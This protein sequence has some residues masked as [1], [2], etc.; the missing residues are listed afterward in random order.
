[1]SE[2]PGEHGVRGEGGHPA[3]PRPLAGVRVL[4]LSRLLPGPLATK[5]LAELG[6]QVDKIED[7]AGGDY[8][9]LMPP[10]AGGMNAVFHALNLGHRSAVLDLKKPEGRAALLRL[11]TRYDVVVESFRPGVLDRLG[12]G[13]GALSAANP[14]LVYCAITG[15]GQTGPLAHRAG[16]DVD[17]LAR[18]GV[19]GM[20]GPEGAAPQ[21]PGMQVA[22]VGGGALFAVS[23]ILAA[24]VA[25]GVTGRGRFVDVSMCEGA[26]AFGLFGL[27]SRYGGMVTPA[28][29]DVLGGGIAPYNT[30]RTRDG[31]AVALGALEPKF[32]GAF[33]RGVGLPFDLEALA[34]GPHQVACKRKVA[35][36]IATRTRDEW[37]AFAA[38]NDCCL[39]PVLEPDELPDDPQH[40]AR[41]VFAHATLAD[42]TRLP[43]PRTPL[44]LGAPIDA[45][46]VAPRHGAHTRE[47]LREAGFDDAEITALGA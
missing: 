20:T 42:G 7:P 28:G 10:Q 15:Y 14:R 13:F 32:W 33:C 25:R 23:G 21:L 27:M 22:D 1:L 12:L 36:V 46:A 40:R 41:G 19:L 18:A 9:R 4:D 37:A 35:E 30:Y 31:R 26:L 43:V 5:M 11:V 38:E 47:V 34:P 17:Y 45:A 29:A 3:D 24:L 2:N 8:L 16:H 44:G 6:A 39:E